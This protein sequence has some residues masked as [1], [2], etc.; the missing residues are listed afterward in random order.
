MTNSP[1]SRRGFLHM[2]GALGGSTAVYR[3]ALGLGLLPTAAHASRPDVA[4]L[5]ARGRKSVLILGAGISGLAAAYELSRKGYDVQVLEASH[6]AGGRN[7]TLRAGDLIDED[8]NPQ[9][10]NFDRDPD[11][12]FN[13]G[14]A[15]IPGHHTSLLGYCKELG[16][17]LSPFINENR[18]AWVQDD[19]MFGG[20]PIRNRE[21][22]TDS[23]GFIAELLAKSM[24]PEQFNATFTNSDYQQVLEYVRQFGELDS[25]FK[26]AGSERA[27]FASYDYAKP[28]SFKQP[29]N[30]SELLR[31]RLMF[32]M[33]FVELQDQSAMMMEPVGGMDRIVAGFL[34]K[35]G[36]LVKLQSQVESI[37]IGAKGVDVKYK[38][39]GQS[40]QAHA[41][42]CLTCIPMHLLARLD[43]NFP[44]EY[45]S[46][47]QA[48]SPGKL[49]KIGLQMKERFWE[50]E[51]IYGGISW[52]MQDI[53]QVWYPAHGIH[54][55]KGVVLG[56]Y[57]FD[58]ARGEMF[59]KLSP[60][61]RIQ[62]A[63]RQGEKIHP[64]YGR[65]VESGVSI[66]WHRMKHMYGCAMRWDEPLQ[67]QR[68]NTLQ[69]PVQGHYLIGDQISYHPGWQE[70][71]LHS[72]FHAIAD[73]DRRVR[74]SAA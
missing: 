27:G 34:A 49:F 42:F 17:Q 15:R 57:T 13:A 48:A 23:R 9:R 19:A 37:R 28:P 18:N 56:A 47:F 45:T 38:H 71:A 50:R 33:N 10:C 65:Y 59:A 16:V 8:G 31:S 32:V 3:A 69:S 53:M 39:Q 29:L 4:P 52:T 11:L 35:V 44:K 5:G 25:R 61:E 30:A 2:V 21:Y 41:D 60:A 70:G 20:R 43:H 6:R 26:Y 1:L 66:A 7:L 14:P 46:G 51:G 36:P 72:A 64:G 58:D 68:F 73:I 22:I 62:L 40:L 12:Y 67:T 24:Q 63:I 54:R 74:A 55:E